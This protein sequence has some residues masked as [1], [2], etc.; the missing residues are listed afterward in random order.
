MI[1][2]RRAEHLPI[3]IDLGHQNLKMVQINQRAETLSV[4]AAAQRAC[5]TDG[6]SGI[7]RL[8]VLIPQVKRLIQT[9]GFRGKNV[10]AVLP[11]E[12][13][14]IKTL[15][16]P[17]LPE[18]EMKLAI[19]SETRDLFSVAAGQLAIR[20]IPAGEVRQ[21]T[22]TRHEV[23]VMAVETALIEQILE[24]FNHAGLI[25]DSLD[26]EP[27]AMYRGL[28]RFVRRKE[29]E[30]EVSVMVDIGAEQSQVVIGKGREV[31]FV[32]S[33]EIGSRKINDCVARKLSLDVTEA[34]SL[35]RRFA[36]M[37]SPDKDPVRQTVL[38]A[39]RNM[40]GELAHEVSLCLRYYSVTFRG[41]RPAKLRLLGGEANDPAIRQ[42]MTQSLAVPVQ[43]YQPFQGIDIGQTSL[44]TLDGSLSEW[45]VA[46]GAALRRISGSVHRSAEESQ[47][48]GRRKNDASVVEVVDLSAEIKT[49]GVMEAP[50]RRKRASDA[51]SVEEVARA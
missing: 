40:I 5:E 23:I 41:Q 31:T 48:F 4:Q 12:L 15:R 9:A 35:R 17:S 16:L 29:D 43:I 6:L 51:A 14:Q 34:A 8:G 11:R 13:V 1:F 25:V 37:E 38:D 49:A 42:A 26:F 47:S 30:N 21:G 24:Q 45:G 20:F 3:G 32:K 46:F 44:A 7:N 39:T 50:D 33:I 22:E 36:A 19:E 28:E 2:L 18:S 10:V 27:A